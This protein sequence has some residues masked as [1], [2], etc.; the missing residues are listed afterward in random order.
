M[1]S[2]EIIVREFVTEKLMIAIEDFVACAEA[3]E[4]IGKRKQAETL[5]EIVNAIEQLANQTNIKR[6]AVNQ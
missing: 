3:L 6:R 2:G 5:R 1:K 4:E